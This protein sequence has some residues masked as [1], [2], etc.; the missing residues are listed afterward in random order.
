MTSV[1]EDIIEIIRS[2]A[3]PREPDTSDENKALL[4]TGLDS[5]DYATVIMAVEEKYKLKIT[6]QNIG[7]LNS[8]R[9]IVDF[10]EAHSSGPNRT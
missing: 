3:K 7:T 9:E 10:V 8:L 2:A 4:E 6:E 5:L 1:R